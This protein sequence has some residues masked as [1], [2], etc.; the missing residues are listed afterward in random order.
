MKFTWFLILTFFCV[1]GKSQGFK[2]FMPNNDPAM[3][4]IWGE[5]NK[6]LGGLDLNNDSAS[7]VNN[8]EN[9]ITSKSNNGS[10]ALNNGSSK[11]LIIGSRS[12]LDLGTLGRSDVTNGSV[13][14]P[15]V[16]STSPSSSSSMI[17][18]ANMG[19]QLSLPNSENSTQ[20]CSGLP[21]FGGLRSNGSGASIGSNEAST[22]PSDLT[23]DQ[24]TSEVNLD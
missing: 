21:A 5:L 18:T 24:E 23:K 9:G 4:G 15:T 19:R 20:N 11:F 7:S 6:V 12:S 1:T 10:S 16:S 8:Y 3:T 2:S 22:P 17:N 13:G 14:A